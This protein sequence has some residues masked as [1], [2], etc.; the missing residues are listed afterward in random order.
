MK[1]WLTLI[2][3]PDSLEDLQ[4]LI[5]PVIKYFDGLVVTYHG[6]FND[7]ESKYLESQKKDGKI[8]YL[9]Y[10]QRQDF[11]RNA[12]LYCGPMSNGDWFIQIDTLERLGANFAQKMKKLANELPDQTKSNILFYHGK[13]FF[14]EYHESL[15]YIGSP[16]PGLQRQDGEGR[17]F[18]YTK[19]EPDESKV[20]LNI[21]PLK[22][23]DPFHWVNHYGTYMIYPFGSNHSLL[24]LEQRCKTQEEMRTN[25]DLREKNR[26]A[27]IDELAKRG[28]ERTIDGV[29]LMLSEPLDDKIKF[30]LNSEKVWQDVYRYNVLGDKTVVDE[31]KWESMIEIK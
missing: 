21:R 29:I 11:S 4:E 8:I 20:R 24:G 5:N 7:P 15:S 16:H 23:T 31:H 27:F 28:F 25:F 2:A 18:D 17:G 12:Y 22:R 10:G 6:D 1:I 30:F 9:P 26:M 13:P 14:I 3:G 19:I